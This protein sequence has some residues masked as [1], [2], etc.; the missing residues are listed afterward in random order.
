MSRDL[1][2]QLGELGPECRAVVARLRAGREAQPGVRVASVSSGSR[3]SRQAY[4]VAASLLVA[5]A[6]GVCFTQ[7]NNRTIEQSEQS[8]QSTTSPSAP[9]EYVMTVSEMLA[10]QNPDGS[11]KTDFLTRRNAE[12]LRVCTGS[13]ARV[14]YKKAMRNLRARGLL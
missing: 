13:D 12:A 11:W 5:A 14:A 9:R 2:E 8:E 7:S 4:L 3:I 10:T 1:E 6:L